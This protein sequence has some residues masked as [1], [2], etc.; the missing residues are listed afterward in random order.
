LRHVLEA[1]GEE[2]QRERRI[3]EQYSLSS[4]VCPAPFN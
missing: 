1:R 4:L 3:T 2:R